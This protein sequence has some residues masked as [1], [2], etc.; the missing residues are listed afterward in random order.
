MKNADDADAKD[1]YGGVGDGLTATANLLRKY[2]DEYGY[3]VAKADCPPTVKA[4]DKKVV[5]PYKKHFK[6]LRSKYC[7]LKAQSEGHPY[8][9]GV[10]AGLKKAYTWLKEEFESA[11]GSQ[12][13]L[14]C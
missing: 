10:A 3:N 7:P 5:F 13:S 2:A 9:A 11:G 4:R 1:R 8:F 6:W 14:S 12:S